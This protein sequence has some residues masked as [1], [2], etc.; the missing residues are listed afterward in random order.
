MIN[1]AI[2]FDKTTGRIYGVIHIPDG[3]TTMP[4]EMM[5]NNPDLDIGGKSYVKAWN[6]VPRPVMP[7]AISAH[8]LTGIPAGALVTVG[9][10]PYVVDD[11][12]LEI[13]FTH[14]G[15]YQVRISLFPYLDFYC[16]MTA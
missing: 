8:S 12:E 11:G 6:I 16:E 15:I 7:I 4:G 5:A 1:N 14:P 13:S 10:T 3:K 2:S 9:I